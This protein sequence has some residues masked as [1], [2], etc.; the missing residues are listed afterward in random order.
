MLNKINNNISFKGIYLYPNINN[1]NTENKAK[2]SEFAKVARQAF[3]QN[4]IFL[5]ADANGEL[6]MRVQKTNPLHLLMDE[7]IAKKMNL[8]L[9]EL[10]GL[11]DIT[12]SYQAVHDEVWGIKRAYILDKTENIND[13]DT[14]DLSYQFFRTIDLFNKTHKEVEN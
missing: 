10:A 12:T 14:M 1:L 3:P 2:A 11:I 8:T 7:E 9:R 6:F 4:D 5:G 13:M